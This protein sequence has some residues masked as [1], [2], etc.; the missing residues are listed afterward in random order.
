[1][2]VLGFVIIWYLLGITGCVLGEKT[3][4][5]KGKNFTINDLLGGMFWSLFGAIIFMFGLSYF[6]KHS[7]FGNRVL[8]KGNQK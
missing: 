8:V 1:M 2:S 5:S 3:D 6:L 7:N 4:M